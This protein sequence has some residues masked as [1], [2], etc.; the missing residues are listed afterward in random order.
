MNRRMDKVDSD[1]SPTLI[2]RLK[3][4]NEQFPEVPVRD[5]QF[6]GLA[7]REIEI[8]KRLFWLFAASFAFFLL[9]LVCCVCM[10]RLRAWGCSRI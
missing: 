8:L 4:F 1:G 9:L 2:R 7:V 10:A 3:I 5:G 6:S